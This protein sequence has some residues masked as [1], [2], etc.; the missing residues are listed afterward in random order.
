MV[1]IRVRDARA[2]WYW[3]QCLLATGRG[4][5]EPPR[6]ESR[7]S[8]VSCWEGRTPC[9][10]HPPWRHKSPSPKHLLGGTAWDKAAAGCPTLPLALES[11]WS[12]KRDFCPRATKKMSLGRFFY[13]KTSSSLGS[14]GVT[15]K[16]ILSIS[17]SRVEAFGASE[18]RSDH[19]QRGVSSPP[20]PKRCWKV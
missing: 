14:F 2:W 12:R 9:P 13:K 18:S 5:D 7:V 11:L 1:C 16:R 3:D 19:L 15:L 6:A 4:G 17:Y 8:D 20:S 10:A